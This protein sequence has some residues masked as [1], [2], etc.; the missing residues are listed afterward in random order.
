MDIFDHIL[1]SRIENE[2]EKNFKWNTTKYETDTM[3]ESSNSKTGFNERSNTAKEPGIA[4]TK[5]L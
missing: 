3:F 5:G 1:S 2:Q 4:N